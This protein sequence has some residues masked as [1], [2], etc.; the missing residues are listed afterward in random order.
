MA[1]DCL[2]VQYDT[3]IHSIDLMDSFE[4]C[5]EQQEHLY[6]KLFLQ[7]FFAVLID[8]VIYQVD[9][10][11]TRKPYEMPWCNMGITFTKLR[12]QVAGRTFTLTDIDVIDPVFQMLAILRENK[13]LRDIVIDPLILK[14]QSSW[15]RIGY[16]SSYHG[17][18]LSRPGTLYG[19]TTPY[20]IQNLQVHL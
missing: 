19:E 14:A 5:N 18:Q 9:I 13:H 10:F 16:G 4:R 7:D 1:M 11:I 3:K 6:N 12:K 15:N 8:R 17:K 20:L 2:I